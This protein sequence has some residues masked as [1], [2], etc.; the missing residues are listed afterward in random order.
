MA[1][2]IVEME[3]PETNLYGVVEAQSTDVAADKARLVWFD[4]EI[5][6]VFLKELPSDFRPP[7][8]VIDNLISR[9]VY[10]A[11]VDKAGI[12]KD[13]IWMDVLPADSEEIE[14]MEELLAQMIDS[15]AKMK[16]LH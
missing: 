7:A 8:L 14:E 4:Q 2:F 9:D 16:R 11:I 1:L 13:D 6:G 3:T 15:Y 12:A 10:D 5:D